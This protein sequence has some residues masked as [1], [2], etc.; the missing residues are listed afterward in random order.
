MVS[1][2]KRMEGYFLA[3]NI[4][5]PQKETCCFSLYY[6][7]T[8]VTLQSIEKPNKLTDDNRIYNKLVKEGIAP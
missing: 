5:E 2:F 3:N 4:V 7:S 1:I 8:S 6:C